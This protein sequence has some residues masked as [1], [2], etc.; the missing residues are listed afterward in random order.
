LGTVHCLLHPPLVW[1]WPWQHHSTDIMAH[2]GTGRTCLSC[3]PPAC[4][5]HNSGDATVQG[6]VSTCSS[7]FQPGGP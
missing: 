2:G 4:D 7:L 3:D 5:K 1:I 6:D